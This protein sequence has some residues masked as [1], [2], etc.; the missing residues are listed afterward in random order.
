MF[1]N[2]KDILLSL[3]KEL[4]LLI[5]TKLDVENWQFI[6]D[7]I[8]NNVN[9]R[10]ERLNTHKKLMLNSIL[11]RE[12]HHIDINRIIVKNTNNEEE[13]LLEETDILRETAKHFKKIMDN[14]VENDE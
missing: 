14:I 5:K 9:K 6:I 7:Q 2:N 10:L 11:E 4:S 13:L 8:E 12:Q 3:L 1:S